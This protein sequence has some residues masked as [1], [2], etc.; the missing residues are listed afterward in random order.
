[1]YGNVQN[2]GAL[3]SNWGN[4]VT[5]PDWTSPPLDPGEEALTIL[6][7]EDEMLIR[8]ALVDYLEDNGFEVVEAGDAA[9]AIQLLLYGDIIIDAVFTDICMPG[10][11]DGLGL[12]AWI[13]Q[14]RVGLP[15]IVTSGARRLDAE[16]AGGPCFFDKPYDCAEVADRLHAMIAEC[17]QRASAN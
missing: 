9:S 3:A 17:R 13:R 10:E 7:V 14:N 15:T 16:A 12:V 4:R 5:A 6:V 8:V 2:E 11:M 1:M